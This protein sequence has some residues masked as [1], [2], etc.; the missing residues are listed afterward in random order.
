MATSSS[1]SSSEKRL[2]SLNDNIDEQQPNNN[3]NN[4]YDEDEFD[5]DSVVGGSSHGNGNNI[6]SGG[7]NKN[8]ND[9]SNN[10]SNNRLNKPTT[11][12]DIEDSL[13]DMKLSESDPTPSINKNSHSTS[14]SNN[15]NNRVSSNN[16]PTTTNVTTVV[17]ATNDKKSSAVVVNKLVTDGNRPPW[18][19]NINNETKIDTRQSY[20]DPLRIMNARNN[21]LQQQN[22]NNNNSAAGNLSSRRQGGPVGG[23]KLHSL[24]ENDIDIYLPSS[25]PLN[26]RNQ[27]S[28][29][30]RYYNNNNNNNSNNNSNLNNQDNILNVHQ[31]NANFR[32]NH[33]NSRDGNLKFIDDHIS[34]FLSTSNNI[35]AALS[36]RL[37]NI[38]MLRK[39]W[40]KSD[41]TD[42]LDYLKVLHE[43]S[44][45]D[46]SNMI[47]LNDFF[48]SINLKSIG[49][50]LTH[51]LNMLQIFDT[52]LYDKSEICISTTVQSLVVLLQAFADLI[53]DTRHSLTGASMVDISKEERLQ[54]C[55]SC[56]S[57]LSRMKTNRI[58]YIKKTYRKSNRIYT[59]LIQLQPLIDLAVS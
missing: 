31:L 27:H 44:R 17:K 38:R 35:S 14:N 41:M 43:G 52:M 30:D 18:S 37:M 47:T 29:D 23:P 4:S 57:I 39:L 19:D 58:E 42:V 3:N 7:N 26:T 25:H 24:E 53:H 55:N 34:K 54:K 12:N 36:S 56:V 8:I 46:P 32:S 50:N 33:N 59:L 11:V 51:C 15:N 22:N 48:A 49:L 28:S 13:E 6:T 1:S 2:K 5:N 20:D 9:D 10:N 21:Q 16:P 40:Q 45:L